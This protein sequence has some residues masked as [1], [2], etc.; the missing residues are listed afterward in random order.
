[1]MT[2]GTVQ[3]EYG[4]ATLGID[5]AA[6][7][8]SWHLCDERRGARQSAYQVLVA[9]SRAVLDSDTGDVWDSG[10]VESEQSIHIVYA[11]AALASRQRVHWKVRVWDADGAPS[12]WSE[13]ATWEMGLRDRADWQAQWIAAPLAGGPWTTVPCPFMR[14]EFACKKA[15][16]QARLYVTALGLYECWLNGQ[17]VG[18]D[19]LAPGWTDYHKRVQYR[20]Y[21]VTPL[22]QRGANALGAVLGDGWYCGHVEWRSRQRYGDR[23]RLLAQL[24][25]T[26]KD[27]TRTTV[28]SD[29]SW[30]AA[31]GP[32]LEADLM[33]G[34][35]YDARLEFIDWAVP[36]FA[37]H[38]WQ[39]VIVCD[40]PGIALDAQRGPVVRRMQELPPVADPVKDTRQWRRTK[41]VFDL[42]QNM[43]GWVR[44]RASGPAGTTLTIRHAEML[45]PDGTIYTANLRSA[46]CTDHYTLRGG[47]E[48]VYEP[49]FTFHGFRYVEIMGAPDDML[50]TRDSVTGIVIH[51]DTPRTG[52]FACSDDLVN[53]LQRNIE[54]GQRGN[55]VD[56]PTD[57]PQ[58]DERLGWTGD[59]QVFIRT[60]AHNMQVAGFFTKWLQDLVDAQG[61]NGE[62]PPTA[63][64][65]AVVEG[66]GG[67]AWADAMVICPWTIYLCYGDTRILETHYPAMQRFM[68]FLCTT[69]RDY[70]RAPDDAGW[71]GFGDWLSINADT[72]KD[73]IG[74]AFFAYSAQ[75]MAR[76]ARV[77]AKEQDAQQ[78]AALAETVR[79]AFV[80]R[81]VTPDGLLVSKTQTAYVLALQFDLLPPEL[82]ARAA[83]E[84]VNDAERRGMHL[85]TGFV[86]APYLPHALTACGKS[87]AAYAL[88]L[89]KTWPS[90]L[91]A[92]T[93][94]ATTIW[95][96]WDGWTHDKGFQDPGMNSFN[97]YA[98]GSVGE[99]L[100]QRVAGID[101]DAAQP[102]FRHIIMRPLW[103]GPLTSARA[104]L[105]SPYG[106]IVS[107]WQRTAQGVRWDVT[108]PP[109]ARATLHL[110]V[111][112]AGQVRESG[113]P[114]GQAAGV[115]CAQ[116][117]EGGM[118]V[119]I[120]AGVYHFDIITST[121]MENT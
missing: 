28:C 91:Y 94:G 25:L 46:K 79:A 29:G 74:T 120:G 81:F 90:W 121:D 52:S 95:E 117:D 14:K 31:F 61:R 33:M 97:H 7:R 32:L 116:A 84:I 106:E 98:Y 102:G 54:W 67:P 105:R 104:T 51:S 101:A 60:A 111:G 110:P 92:V 40:D 89:Q 78:Y 24:E 76:I 71:Q 112:D 72:P 80:R 36:G 53:Q 57:C 69:A 83:R 35:S 15:V 114:V 113:V 58:R 17:R 26:H 23:P 75:L 47:G 118:R 119:S 63:P 115:A 56:I 64:S 87:D 8:L 1:M 48:E 73:L 45:N 30:R 5:V 4:H 10:R 55:F 34:E 49:R 38:A 13:P 27:G 96:R 107:A 2:V 6:P 16:V 19:V 88:L 18:D 43:V 70:I 59:A 100:Y 66:D 99:W 82:R 86:G 21:D 3:C 109:N 42:G 65:T 39:P 93:Q 62:I 20:T 50:L 9:S 22:V 37:D 108:V 12:P 41:W 77:L 11:G 44:L 85:S 68:E 103:N